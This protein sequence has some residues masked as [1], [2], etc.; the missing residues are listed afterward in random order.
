MR[1]LAA[2]LLALA[3]GLT[4]AASYAVVAQTGV[5]LTPTFLPQ[6]LVPSFGF[7]SSSY[8]N[9]PFMYNLNPV[10]PVAGGTVGYPITGFY[11]VCIPY[12][13]A[14]LGVSNY[15]YSIELSGGI[16]GGTV[17]VEEFKPNY[18][19]PQ[20]PVVISTFSLPSSPHNGPYVNYASVTLGSPYVTTPGSTI[21]AWVTGIA[22][23][24]SQFYTG[25]IVTAT[26]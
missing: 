17:Q 26:I 15:P 11:I 1:K 18:G 23:G 21:S 2:A 20:S 3:L 14:N 12:S 5:N 16:G 22:S 9:E 4:P 13:N 10:L 7:T 24:P 25:C 6:G 19:T 8:P